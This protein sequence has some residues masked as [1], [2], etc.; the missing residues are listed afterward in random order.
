MMSSDLGGLA[1]YLL[2]I[3]SFPPRIILRDDSLS[4]SIYDK[5]NIHR[6]KS[7]RSKKSASVGITVFALRHFLPNILFSLNVG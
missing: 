5:S 1:G 7:K 2:Y 4:V 3:T 6:G